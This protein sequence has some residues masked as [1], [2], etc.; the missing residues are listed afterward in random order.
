MLDHV[1]AD[2]AAGENVTGDKPE[3]GLDGFGV[4]ASQRWP[5]AMFIA[6]RH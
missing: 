2:L 5:T 3:A 4:V 6:E 1:R